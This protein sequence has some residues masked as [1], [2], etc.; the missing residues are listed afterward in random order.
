MSPRKATPNRM[1]R[2]ANHGSNTL[3]RAP[4]GR[5]DP[6][7]RLRG[8]EGP[9]VAGT[10]GKG[11]AEASISVQ[12]DATRTSVRVT[13]D[14]SGHFALESVVAGKYNLNAYASGYATQRLGSVLSSLA[15]RAR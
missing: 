7:H 11:V 2:K 10:T 5:G 12:D 8:A 9:V 6:A 15:R 13:T 3:E 4:P 1:A 14:P